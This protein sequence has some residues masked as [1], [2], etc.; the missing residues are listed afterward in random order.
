MQLFLVLRVIILL[1]QKWLYVLFVCMDKCVCIKQETVQNYKVLFFYMLL[2]QTNCYCSYK[3]GWF[4]MLRTYS[5]RNNYFLIH[6]KQENVKMWMKIR[7]RDTILKNR[8]N[9][10][11]LLTQEKEFTKGFKGRTEHVVLGQRYLEVR[12]SVCL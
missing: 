7:I 10:D 1:H 2:P 4:F 8:E 12:R 9:P 5:S 11:K 6:I 3:T